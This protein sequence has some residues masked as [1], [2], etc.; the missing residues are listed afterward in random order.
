MSGC[1]GLQNEGS[2]RT[3]A[4]LACFGGMASVGTLTGLAALEV[5]T[6]GEG[7]VFCLASLANGDPMVQQRPR[8]AERVAAVDGCPLACARRIAERAGFPPPAALVLTH[9]PGIKKGPPPALTE[10]DRERAVE[11]IRN[12][13]RGRDRAGE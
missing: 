4:L 6:A 12:A 10:E 1:W 11:A 9:D 5:V 2:A 8:E 7:T 3:R 13:L